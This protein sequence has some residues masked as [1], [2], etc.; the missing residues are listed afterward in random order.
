MPAA[1]MIKH[2]QG[3]L[4]LEERS[5]KFMGSLEDAAVMMG[6]RVDINFSWT[7]A[8]VSMPAN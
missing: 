6:M 4:P 8:K 3:A 1:V 5:Q 2:D 7:N